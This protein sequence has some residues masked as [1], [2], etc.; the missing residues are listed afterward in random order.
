MSEAFSASSGARASMARAWMPRGISVPRAS[1]TRR[2]RATRAKPLKRAL[3][4]AHREM[5]AFAGAGMAGVQ[6][7]VV[8]D[9]ELRPAASA[10]AQRALD[11]A[12]R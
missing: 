10:L 1:Y 2:C 7:A 12:A 4:I 11:L 3:T 6:V 9:L 5:A 8:D